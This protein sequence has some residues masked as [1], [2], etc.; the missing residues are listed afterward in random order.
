MNKKMLEDFEVKDKR[1]LVR[2]DLNVPIDEN[3]DITDDTRIRAA[4]PTI[5]Y[6]I[7]KDAKV[8]LVSHFGRPKGKVN[9]KYSLAPVAK[10]LSELL[11]KEVVM[12]PDC[13]GETVENLV[14]Q[15]KPKDVILLENVRFHEGEEKNDPEFA[16]K[17]AK[18]ADIFINDAFGTSHRAHASTVGVAKFLPAGAGYLMQKEIEIM[19]NALE[20][21]ERPFVAILGGAKVGDKIGVIK[22][23]LSKV[24]V[25]LIGGGM[26]YT[27]L[28]SQGYE[29]GKSL[30][31]SDKIELAA[32]LL[33]EAKEKNVKLLLP[34]DVVV[35]SELKEGL[36]YETVSIADIPKDKMGVDIGEKTREKFADIIKEAK[37]VIW[38][39]P[40]GVFEIEEYAAGTLA[41]AKAMAESKAVT[42]IGG[43]DSAA[44]VE[45]MGLAKYM[46]HIS[47]GGGASLEFLEGKEL[48]GVAALNDK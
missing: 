3:G 19:G 10:R 14:A 31:E 48:P 37:T 29:I 7:S 21:P 24:D 28:K 32:S 18:L 41:V 1:V 8:I 36:P 33:N 12:A 20:N 45:Q 17:L 42:I 39:G 22:N 44:A 2:V 27:F 30:L 23:L 5:N 34:D 4:L 46:T 35:T 9:P 15:M 26:A 40:M 11:D 13:I 16:R 25:L 43:G 38:N 6:L 47:T